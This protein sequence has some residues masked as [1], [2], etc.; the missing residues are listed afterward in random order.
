MGSEIYLL[1]N[2]TSPTRGELNPRKQSD[3]LPI[4]LPIDILKRNDSSPSSSECT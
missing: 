1:V 2:H 3:L 4:K